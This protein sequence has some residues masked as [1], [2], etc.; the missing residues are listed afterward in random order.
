[1]TLRRLLLLVTL[2]VI[3]HSCKT[4]AQEDGHS[5]NKIQQ[6]NARRKNKAILKRKDSFFGLHFDFH[7]LPD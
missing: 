3:G 6:E 1:M 4:M 5:P 2:F 7:A